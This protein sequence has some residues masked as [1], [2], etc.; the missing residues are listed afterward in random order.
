M[1]LPGMNIYAMATR[2]IGKSEYTY[3]AASRVL[4]DRGIWVDTF[5]VGVALR[6]SIQALPRD[7]YSALGLDLSRYYVMIFTDNPL[8]VVERDSS[9]DQVEFNGDRFQLLS[10]T[11]WNPIDSWR[12]VLAVRLPATVSP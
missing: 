7:L 5:A 6:D 4:D 3:F 9:G 1:N 11:D 10:D 8:L 2:V 12:E